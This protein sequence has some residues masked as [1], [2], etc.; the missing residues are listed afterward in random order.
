MSPTLIVNVARRTRLSGSNLEIMAPD[1]SA[2]SSSVT[3]GVPYVGSDA[4]MSDR[5]DADTAS[6]PGHDTNE[7]E[8][9][10]TVHVLDQTSFQPD[11]CVIPRAVCP[12]TLLCLCDARVCTCVCMLVCQLVLLLLFVFLYHLRCV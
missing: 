8:V 5:G 10:E 6:F 3:G 9:H 7:S 4:A 12:A 11:E 2:D 1:A